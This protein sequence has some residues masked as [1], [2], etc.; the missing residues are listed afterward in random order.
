MCLT[1]PHT[2]FLEGSVFW[3]EGE[4]SVGEIPP[5]EMEMKNFVIP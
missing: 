5:K 3:E 4:W 1:M 2:Y